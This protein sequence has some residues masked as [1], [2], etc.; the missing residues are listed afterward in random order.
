MGRIPFP[1]LPTVSSARPLSRASTEVD[2]SK[3]GGGS[4]IRTERLLLAT[5]MLFQAEL[6]P[7]M[8]ERVGVEPTGPLGTTGLQP[9]YLADESLSFEVLGRARWHARRVCKSQPLPMSGSTPTSEQS[10]L[11]K[12]KHRGIKNPGGFANR[13]GSL[14]G[15][16]L[17]GSN[18]R[19]SRELFREG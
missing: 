5:Q 11:L 17:E 14:L 13:P 1:P 15:A 7:R 12:S 10:T 6:I 9:V 2:D 16:S 18:D 19:A 3:F 4:R 8:V